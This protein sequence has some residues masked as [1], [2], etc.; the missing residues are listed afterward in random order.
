M[1]FSSA[2]L[3]DVAART[4]SLEHQRTPC[5]RS[6]NS[7]NT[8]SKPARLSAWPVMPS[9]SRH[10]VSVL[11]AVGDAAV[12]IARPILEEAQRHQASLACPDRRSGRSRP[13][14][15]LCRADLE[16]QGDLQLA[17]IFAWRRGGSFARI[18]REQVFVV[19]IGLFVVGHTVAIP[20]R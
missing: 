13:R 4:P 20:S 7:R 6:H 1:M 9:A 8:P 11:E 5:P 10:V 14:P 2:Y 16:R 18:G 12:E 19:R 17:G 15:G 3:S